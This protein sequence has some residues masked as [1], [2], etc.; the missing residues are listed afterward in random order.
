MA[1]EI[2][3]SRLIILVLFEVIFLSFILKYEK[4]FWQKIFLLFSFL[5]FF[6]YNGIGS[7][8]VKT[9]NIYIYYYFIYSI[10]YYVSF[11]ASLSIYKKL[12]I[13]NLIRNKSINN[14][15]TFIRSNKYLNSIII[16]YLFINLLNLV[17]PKFI[18]Y[19]LISPPMPD[20]M[21]LLSQEIDNTGNSLIISRIIYYISLTVFPFY[22]IALSKYKNKPKLLVALL[23]LPVYITYCQNSYIS[24]GSILRI[25]FI[26]SLSI[27]YYM[28]KYRKRIII[29]GIISIPFL[30]SFFYAYSVIRQ[31]GNFTNSNFGFAMQI[32]FRQE[33]EFPTFFATVSK[34][35]GLYEKEF[36]IWLIT[37]PFPKFGLIHLVP[38]NYQI[39]EII[40]GMS[41]YNPLYYVKLA[42]CI[43]ESVY[44]FGNSFFWLEAIIVGS[45]A[46]FVFIII[47]NIPNN[48]ILLGLVIISFSYGYPRAGISGIA[49]FILNQL[50]I[51]YLYIF[52]PPLSRHHKFS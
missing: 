36:L 22:Y 14:K 44:I 48:E 51:L 1:I 39:S 30:I 42:G 16:F 38:V 31:N 15:F 12:G 13:R 43:S 11:K 52:S 25:L 6:F 7:I 17:Y 24:R 10:I 21:S 46:G 32:L 23:F 33:T 26:S 3:Q 49:P 40:L 29:L 41:K 4:N 28:P 20:A 18:L 50:L 47:K 5:G 34:H 35:A 2:I 27:Y 19:R 8:Y 9:D 37:L 45:L